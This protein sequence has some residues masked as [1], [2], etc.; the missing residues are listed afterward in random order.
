ME[1]E[2]VVSEKIENPLSTVQKVSMW[3]WIVELILIWFTK[4]FEISYQEMSKLLSLFS[5]V[6]V[7]E[8]TLSRF[9]GGALSLLD[10]QKFIKIFG[11]MSYQ[12]EGNDTL[13]K[14]SVWLYYLTIIFCITIAIHL[15]AML[16]GISLSALLFFEWT[17][18][19]VMIGMT[20]RAFEMNFSIFFIIGSILPFVAS[21]MAPVSDAVNSD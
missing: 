11:E 3:M 1:N 4:W 15:I 10:Y 18:L 17:V 19:L 8:K 21:L 7:S 20:C 2:S 13:N 5:F 16:N 12:L 14:Y 9:T 6:G